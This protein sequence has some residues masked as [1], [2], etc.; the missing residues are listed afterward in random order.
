MALHKPGMVAKA[1]KPAFGKRM[2]EDQEFRVGH[3]EFEASL[4]YTR[5][6]F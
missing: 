3:I 6:C 5:L 1:Y 2:Q 4:G